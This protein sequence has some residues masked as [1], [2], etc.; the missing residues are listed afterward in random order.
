MHSG[1]A[2]IFSSEAVI[3]LGVFAAVFCAMAIAEAAAP[4][5]VR[6]FGRGPRWT[7]NL[8]IA[9][10]NTVIVRILIPTA[11][12][13][14]ALAAQR[15]HFGLFNQ[16]AIGRWPAFILAIVALDLVIYL[17]HV[18]FHAVPA[19]WRVHRTHHADPDFDVTTGVRFH[20]VEIVLSVLIKIAAVGALGAA[21]EAVV[22][23]EVLLNATSM[24]SHG[25][26]ALP[27]RADRFLRWFLVTPDMHRVHHSVV[28]RETNSNFGFNLPWWDYLLG[29]Y[30]AAPAAGQLGMTIGIEG[31]RGAD[32]I[33][34]TAMLS[35]P[36][37]GAVGAYP[38]GDKD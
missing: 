36:L 20:P 23:F 3:R 18:M 7:G 13:G 33:A 26:L 16:I 30:R 14:A 35:H 32:E 19:L 1:L 37:R 27:A 38:L 28:P 25:N 17:Q 4:R 29:T 22:T 6:G 10:L 34:L 9:V 8:G 5:R 24:F 15:S 12:V 31:F 2:R 11:A 21:P